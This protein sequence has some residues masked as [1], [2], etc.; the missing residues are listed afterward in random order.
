MHIVSDVCCI[1]YSWQAALAGIV[2]TEQVHAW[3]EKE[4]KEPCAVPLATIQLDPSPQKGPAD[5]H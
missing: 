5:H 1:P 2:V 3:D 4:Q